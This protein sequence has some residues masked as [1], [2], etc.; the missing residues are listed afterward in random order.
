VITGKARS[1][2]RHCLKSLQ[3]DE[4]I[5]LGRRLMEKALAAL[6]QSLAQISPVRLDE[7]LDAMKLPDIDSLMVEIGL[8]NRMAAWWR[9]NWWARNPRKRA[10]A[11]TAPPPHS[12]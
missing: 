6:G 4:A 10:R 9:G 3:T 7:A 2:I 12:R 1:G 11:R 5:V 8:G